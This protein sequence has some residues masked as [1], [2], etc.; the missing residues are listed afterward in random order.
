MIHNTTVNP[1]SLLNNSVN[2]KPVHVWQGK[3]GRNYTD[4]NNHTWNELDKI[5]TKLYGMTRSYLNTIFLENIPRDIKILEIGTNIGSQLGML[6]R[7]GFTSLHGIEVQAYALEKARQNLPGADLRQASADAI[8]FPDKSFD[9][10]FTSGVLIHISPM[11]RDKVISEMI[12]CSRKW[13]WGF[14]YF[15]QESVEITYHGNSGLMWKMDF[16]QLFLDANPLAQVV[17]RR[18]IPYIADQ[19]IDEMY[20]IDLSA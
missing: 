9:L 14:E 19:N 3:F 11:E 20:L 5:H 7:M 18:K 10:V 1:E 17:L 6:S 16:C 2:G 13:I 4:R 12:R 8:P 15:S